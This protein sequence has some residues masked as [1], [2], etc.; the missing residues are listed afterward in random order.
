MSALT[1]PVPTYWRKRPRFWT[2]AR[3]FELAGYLERGWTDEQIG[4]QFG[5][6][7]TAIQL[8][9]KR[10][11]LNARRKN[12]L[13]ARQIA[14][15]MGVPCAK[16]VARWIERGHLKGRRGQT[17]GPYRQWYVTREA[18][19][20]FLQDPAYWHLWDAARL[21]DP[22]LRRLYLQRRTERYLTVGEVA[23]R[24]FVVQNA[25][26]DWIHRGVLPAVRR[27]NWLIPESALEGFVPPGQRSKVGMRRRPWTADEDARLLEL[28]AAGL[29]WVKIGVALGRS[30]GSVANRHRRLVQP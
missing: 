20:D 7:A 16:T 8:A 14:R 6:S 25:V 23:E 12:L 4:R 5:K 26:N 1:A 30:T 13:S 21:A 15:E 24:C 27:G 29:P 11:G 19:T 9:R 17:W 18:L 10:H 3:L 28:R 22:D 2:P